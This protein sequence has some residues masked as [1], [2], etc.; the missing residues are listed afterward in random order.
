MRTLTVPAP[1]LRRLLAGVI[2]TALSAASAPAQVITPSFAANPAARVEVAPAV[3]WSGAR[4]SA[5]LELRV[6]LGDHLGAALRAGPDAW[7]GEV[8]PGSRVLT[9]ASF[10][11]AELRSGPTF[12]LGIRA[13]SGP[14]RTGVFGGVDLARQSYSITAKSELVDR[15]ELSWRDLDANA[16]TIAFALLDALTPDRSR[17]RS[18]KSGGAATNLTISGGYAFDLGPGERLELTARIIRRT[19]PG[20]ATFGVAEE[21]GTRYFDVADFGSANALAVEARWVLPLW[22]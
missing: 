12:G 7:R 2:L 14:E 6:G 19:L 21:G 3:G 11:G 8:A 16:V 18:V 4:P 5:A 10:R 13:Y 22:R 1:R 17:R 20:G 15:D 9:G